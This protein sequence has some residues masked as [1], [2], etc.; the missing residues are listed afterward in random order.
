MTQHVRIRYTVQ[1]CAIPKRPIIRTAHPDI[2]ES[3][4]M[5][6]RMWRIR[7]EQTQRPR[8]GSSLDGLWGAPLLV[9][10]DASRARADLA[11]LVLELIASAALLERCLVLLEVRPVVL[12]P[13]DRHDEDERGHDTD[14]DAL[15]RRIVRDD[16]QLPAR[17]AYRCVQVCRAGC[18]AG[19]CVG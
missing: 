8:N 1:T 17:V 11:H 18:M 5:P 19:W 13:E 14:Q 4:P 12:W 15:H 16:R 10:L 7:I 6:M 2:D 9:D 3:M